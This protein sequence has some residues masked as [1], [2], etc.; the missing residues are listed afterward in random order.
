[1]S[2]SALTK[3]AFVAASASGTIKFRFKT[4]TPNYQNV[5]FENGVIYIECE[6]ENFGMNVGRVESVRYDY[7]I[8]HPSSGKQCRYFNDSVE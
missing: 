2:K 3:E 4:P 6:P 1:V 5:V 7:H 8:P